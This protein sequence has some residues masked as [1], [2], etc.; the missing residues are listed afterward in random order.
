MPKEPFLPEKASSAFEAGPTGIDRMVDWHVPLT[1]ELDRPDFIARAQYPYK[2]MA[3]NAAHLGHSWIAETLDTLAYYAGLEAQSKYDRP[4][5]YP[6]IETKKG[7]F[8][9][10]VFLDTSSILNFRY[11]GN[12]LAI[13]DLLPVGSEHIT[14]AAI[15]AASALS[16]TT[17]VSLF[18]GKFHLENMVPLESAVLNIEQTAGRMRDVLAMFGLRSDSTVVNSPENFTP[19]SF[20]KNFYPT[21]MGLKV[22]EEIEPSNHYMSLHATKIPYR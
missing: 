13:N 5:D 17:E 18:K 16:G 9:H 19:S 20:Y 3:N 10:L 11:K 1:T 14:H 21:N 2:T 22:R 6:R 15:M 4:Q 12:L 8:P 7:D